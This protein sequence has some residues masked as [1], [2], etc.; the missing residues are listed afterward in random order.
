MTKIT[1]ANMMHTHA[2]LMVLVSSDRTETEASAYQCIIIEVHVVGIRTTSE[3]KVKTPSP[4]LTRIIVTEA[5]MAKK[6]PKLPLDSFEVK[7]KESRRRA[8]D[9]GS[10][11][12]I[13]IMEGQE[14]DTASRPRSNKIHKTSR[15]LLL[16]RSDEN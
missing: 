9:R 6:N 3:D 8:R 16:G 5:F 2:A 12:S 4:H 14:S 1:N 10:V 11:R 15:V 7:V 13:Y